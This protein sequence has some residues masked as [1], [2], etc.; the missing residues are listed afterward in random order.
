LQFGTSLLK[1]QTFG[2]A[3][4]PTQL[5]E[6]LG[7]RDDGFGLLRRIVGSKGLLEQTTE[8]HGERDGGT[9]GQVVRTGVIVQLVGFL[10]ELRDPV[11]GLLVAQPILEAALFPFGEVG[12][13]D[14]A[15]VEVGGEGVFD[16]GEAVEPV[17]EAGAGLAIGEAVVEFF[18]DG[19]REAGDLPVRVMGCGVGG[20]VELRSGG[21][22]GMGGMRRM[23]AMGPVA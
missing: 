3:V 1:P 13:I 19:A 17:D 8:R 2:I 4:G 16:F 20:V 9:I 7:D 11:A 14:G 12:L 5:R 18:A 6:L 22:M 15:S 23:G 10:D 21:V